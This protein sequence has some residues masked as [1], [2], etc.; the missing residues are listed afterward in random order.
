MSYHLYQTLEFDKVLDDL[1]R[2]T[3]SPLAAERLQGL[4]PLPGLEM[5]RK[6][7]ARIS[8]LRAFM[9]SGEAF[10]ISKFQDIGGYLELAAVEGG[11]LEPGAFRH[12]HEVLDL[13]ARIHRFFQK[14]GQIFHSFK[15]SQPL[16]PPTL[17]LRKRSA[18][19]LI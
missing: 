8:E 1:V 13:A 2:R 4:T 11:Y 12:I 19:V 17:F 16:W 9:D 14:T 10:P 6:S 7:L 3:H 5:V 18:R 15:K